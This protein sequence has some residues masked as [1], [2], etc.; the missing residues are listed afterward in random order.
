MRLGFEQAQ[1]AMPG[2]QPKRH[3]IRSARRTARPSIASR[4]LGY[5][6]RRQILHAKY[7]PP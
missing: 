2:F 5:D 1:F 7:G 4:W 3:R 6:K